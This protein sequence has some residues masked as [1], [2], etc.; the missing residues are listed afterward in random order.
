M[1]RESLTLE[2]DNE[3]CPRSTKEISSLILYASKFVPLLGIWFVKIGA[4]YISG[5]H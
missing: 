2:T 4:T 3:V 1:L 5:L